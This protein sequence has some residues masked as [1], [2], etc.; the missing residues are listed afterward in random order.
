[1]KVIISRARLLMTFA[2]V[3]IIAESALT[4][5]HTYTNI[6]FLKGFMKGNF[7]RY[8]DQIIQ[9]C[10]SASKYLKNLNQD[11]SNRSVKIEKS[12][13]VV[14]SRPVCLGLYPR[15]NAVPGV[16]PGRGY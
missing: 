16:S 10:Y 11:P 6:Q 13:H 7:K 1:M 2:H 12:R 9:K 5:R 3:L 14:E 4:L 8:I 15:A